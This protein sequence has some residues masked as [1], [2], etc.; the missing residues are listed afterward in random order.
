MARTTSRALSPV[1]SSDPQVPLRDIEDEVPSYRPDA[2][3][4]AAEADVA[5]TITA[6]AVNVTIVAITAHFDPIGKKL[7]GTRGS[8]W[9]QF[10]GQVRDWGSAS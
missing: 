5:G 7:R 2:T 9:S 8:L 10:G 6:P 1:P 3:P 4:V